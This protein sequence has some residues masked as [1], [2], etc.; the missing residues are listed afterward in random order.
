[1]PQVRLHFG[2]LMLRLPKGRRC[3]LNLSCDS[4][5]W[6]FGS[7]SLLN[8]TTIFRRRKEAK[9]HLEKFDLRIGHM[10]MVVE[11]KQMEELLAVL[12]YEHSSSL[13]APPSC[14]SRF[15][16]GGIKG[17]SKLFCWNG[18]SK[19]SSKKAGKNP[20]VSYAAPW[21]HGTPPPAIITLRR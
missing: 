4:S 12:T 9:D 10:S 13:V 1:M 3:L 15:G 14:S 19:K 6:K 20:Y 2:G 8:K 16:N 7:Y 11:K 5:W 21:P 17:L 18:F